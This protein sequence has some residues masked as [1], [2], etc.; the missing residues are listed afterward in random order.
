MY[1]CI[2]V[3]MYIC[4]YVYMYIYIFVHLYIYVYVYAYMSMYHTTYVPLYMSI[5]THT[6]Q[7]PPIAPGMTAQVRR[8]S[9]AGPGWPATQSCRHEARPMVRHMPHHASHARHA[10]M[11]GTGN[12]FLC[13]CSISAICDWLRTKHG[14]CGRKT[15]FDKKKNAQKQQKNKMKPSEFKR[16]SAESRWGAAQ[17]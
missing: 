16:E 13:N 3:Y 7:H 6:T 12:V 10:T 15:K 8:L 4:L 9:D 5:Y 17:V 11:F 14:V 2:Y 1:V